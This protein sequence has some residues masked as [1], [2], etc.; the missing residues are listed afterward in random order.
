MS[1]LAPGRLHLR[2]QRRGGNAGEAV[3]LVM[4]FAVA[5][6]ARI[7]YLLIF[8]PPLESTYLALADS[9]VD[10]GVLGFSGVPSAS[11]EPIYPAL[12]GAGR[13][14]FGDRT[15]AIQMMQACIAAAGAPL[16]F[17]VALELTSSRRA[18]TAAGLMFALHPLLIRQAAAP[19][20]LALTATLVVACA[21]SFV[22]IR[23]TRSAAAAGAWLGLTALTRSMSI[24]LVVLSAAILAAKRQLREAAALTLVA[25]AFIA[26]MVVRNHVLTGA[27]WPGR[28]GIN[29]FIGNSPNT[30]ALLPTYDLDLLEAEAYDRFI[31]AHPDSAANG[32]TDAE[33]A[34]FLTGEAIGYIAAN[35]W[36]TARQKLINVGYMLS[37]RITPYEVSGPRTRIRVEDGRV[38]GVEDSVERPRSEIA[39][40][41]LVS[42]VLL[43]G[44]AA[45]VYLRR[46]ELF[47]SDAILWAIFGTFV[48]INAI[49]VPA[50][51]YT[52]PVQFVLIFYAAVAFARPGGRPR[53]AVA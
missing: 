3:G 37:P 9:L 10:H 52:A 26:P 41:A 2:A 51:R 45:G 1:P 39:A 15:V 28:S 21:V 6:L 4:V 40:H 38:S 32:G 24:P 7:G 19:T 35:P 17:K 23:D 33:F 43:A 5:F 49:Y 36:A 16:T 22:A 53:D 47:R 13:M 18:A 42:L 30:P 12:L 20:D 46:R 50:T 44:C 34:A 8:R 29:L 27:P 48:V 25:V 11:F 14:V 31:R